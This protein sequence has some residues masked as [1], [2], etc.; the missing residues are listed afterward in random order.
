MSDNA[1]TNETFTNQL[2]AL[3][4]R[5]AS[6]GA[7]PIPQLSVSAMVEVSGAD[8]RADWAAELNRLLASTEARMQELAS[9]ELE[10][11]RAFLSTSKLDVSQV[12]QWLVE[13]KRRCKEG[14]R[15]LIDEFFG[16]A[17]SIGEKHPEAQQLVL[18]ASAR[19]SPFITQLVSE[20]SSHIDDLVSRMTDQ[21]NPK[22]SWLDDV[23]GAISRFFT[24]IGSRIAKFFST[25]R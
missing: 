2:G 9:K 24:D 6:E 18:E 4:K 14:Y 12:R 15:A 22:E 17:V 11:C 3:R 21:A 19:L 16:A 1:Q 8:N 10:G 7:T 20:L 5:H 13:S 25:N 23:V